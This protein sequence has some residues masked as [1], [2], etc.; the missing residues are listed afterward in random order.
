M[1]AAFGFLP[2]GARLDCSLLLGWGAVRGRDVGTVTT[3]A[4]MAEMEKRGQARQGT[5]AP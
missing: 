1:D 3:L 5:E 4:L 2:F